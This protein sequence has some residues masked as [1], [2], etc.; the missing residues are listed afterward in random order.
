MYPLALAPVVEVGQDLGPDGLVQL[1]RVASDHGPLGQVKQEP[2]PLKSQYSK[3]NQSPLV[4][5]KLTPRSRSLY[6]GFENPSA[7]LLTA[8]DSL[9]SA[10]PMFVQWISFQL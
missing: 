7:C 1:R 9:L 4:I 2:A 8:A 6:I 10:L 3:L 5:S